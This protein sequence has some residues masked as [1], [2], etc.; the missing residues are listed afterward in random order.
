MT[1][2]CALCPQ[3][4]SSLIVIPEQALQEISTKVGEH[5]TKAHPEELKKFRETTIRAGL[6]FAWYKLASSFMDIPKTETYLQGILEKH[7]KEIMDLMGFDQEEDPKESAKNGKPTAL[8]EL[9]SVKLPEKEV[10]P[11]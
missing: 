4:I 10:E 8:P 7:E 9:Q 6:I 1:I 11:T 5:V 3:K 2:K